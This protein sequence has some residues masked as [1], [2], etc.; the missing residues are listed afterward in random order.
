MAVGSHESDVLAL[1]REHGELSRTELIAR[2]GLS[3]S[4]VNHRLTA[5]TT[6]GLLVPVEGGESTGGRPSS[7]FE[8][9]AGR[10]AI[11]CADVGATGFTA[12]LC[13]LTGAPLAHRERAIDVWEG[14]EAV[15]CAVLEAFRELPV[16]T[17]VWGIAIGVPGPVEFAARRVVNPPIM[18]GWDRFDIA[19]WFRPHYDAP[20]LVENDAN[21][22]AVAEARVNRL[23][24]VIALKLGTGV[25]AGLVF[26]GE[27]IR[28]E[29]G[30]A[31]DIGHTRA[32]IVDP[33]PRPCRCGSFDCV[34]AYAGGWALQRELAGCGIEVR[35]TADVVERV[36]RGDIETTRRVR[37]AGRVVGDAIADLVG[38]L[39]PRAIALSGRLA[40]CDEVLMAGIRERLYQRATPLVT[41]DLTIARSALGALDGVTGLALIA[42]DAVLAQGSIERIVAG[43]AT[44]A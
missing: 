16:C 19:A 9:N 7:R 44:G 25:G 1:F 18:T 22:R 13:D 26:H 38:I 36:A 35:G 5:L 33:E 24:N 28:G 27:I 17:E 21:A 6:A 4:T 41:R 39:N 37:A 12:A 3:R 34:E 43:S 8:L 40:E 14:P 2:C 30:A 11:L 23:D 29:N 20:V 15:L 32:A 42:S 31:G 10:A